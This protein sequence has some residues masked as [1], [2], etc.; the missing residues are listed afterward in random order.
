MNESATNTPCRHL[1]AESLHRWPLPMPSSE[2]DKEQRGRLLLIGGSP[3][4][5]GAVLLAA[6]SA[7]RAGA[8][9][10]TIATAESI[11]SSVAIA[12]P[13]SRVIGLAET[14]AGGLDPSSIDA[15]DQLIGR[16]GAVLIGP[17]MQDESCTCAMARAVLSRL[18][19]AKLILDAAAMD[20]VNAAGDVAGT[21]SQRK[22]SFRFEAPALLT[23]HAGEMAHLTG[24]SKDE[25]LAEPLEA[26]RAAARRWNAVVAVKGA[27]TFV[28]APDGRTWR[29]DGGSIGLA[30]SGSG[31]TLAGI[32]G[33][34]AARGA[35]LEQACAWGV[36]L[37]ARAGERLATT[38]GP[39]GY[40]AREIPAEV[41]ALL[42]AHGPR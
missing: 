33:G 36:Y 16:A 21:P 11:A 20:I 32:I 22:E 42:H 30:T 12:L 10:V 38:V 27:V 18:R 7:L 2:G 4:I 6:T 37:H 5:P 31:D 19:G 9:K 28:A 24:A 29:H 17:G 25:V 23:P 35:P 41:P 1:D 3:E 14:A 40:L 15:I 39:L 26:A 8:G 13:E 34:L